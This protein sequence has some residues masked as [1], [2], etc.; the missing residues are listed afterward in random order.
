MPLTIFPHAYVRKL[1]D[2]LGAN[3]AKYGDR[4]VWAARAPG[5]KVDLSTRVEPAGP[6]DLELP[7]GDDLKDF[8][9]AVR[10]FEALPALTPR[11]ARDPRLWTRLAHVECW[12]YMRKR[13]DAMKHTADTGKA[14]RYV[15]QHYFVAQSQSRA[16]LRH[17]IARLWWYA[18]LTRDANR[19]DPYELT[20]VLL[21]SLDIAQQLLERNMGRVGEPDHDSPRGGRLSESSRN[22]VAAQWERRTRQFVKGPIPLTWLERAA[23]CPGKAVIIGCLLWYKWGME[24][25]GPVTVS[26]HLLSRFGVGRKAAYR[27]YEELEQAG[28]IGVERGS[29]R[30]PRLT[31]VGV[32]TTT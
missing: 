16:L 31:I 20:R 29:G 9:N 12:A 5:M 30:L 3:L 6:L 22:R 10:V 2:D 17:G 18:Y 24:A 25:P 21:S 15:L 13:W 4:K 27:A 32:S 14:E 7:D 26:H 28:L 11:Q 1:R 19:S 8:K 23:K